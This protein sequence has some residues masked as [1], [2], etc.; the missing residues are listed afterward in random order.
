MGRAV[1]WIHED[2]SSNP[3]SREQSFPCS[4]HESSISYLW[5]TNNSYRISLI[6]FRKQSLL[7][8][9]LKLNSSFLDV[10]YVTTATRVL[11]GKTSKYSIK[12]STYVFS[13][14]KLLEPILPDLSMTKT[15]SNLDGAKKRT[16]CYYYYNCYYIIIIETS[17]WTI[18]KIN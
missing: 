15:K 18:C 3:G 6:A 12:L 16:N 13:S 4:L 7:M 11:A 10:E 8:Y 2:S 14:L 5:N 9:L 17:A 1:V